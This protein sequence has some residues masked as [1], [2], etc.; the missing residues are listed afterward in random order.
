MLSGFW[1]LGWIIFQVKVQ[2]ELNPL[3]WATILASAYLFT[4]TVAFFFTDN[5]FIGFFGDY[6]RRTGYI[7]YFSLT[8]FFLVSAYVL[9][10]DRLALL[11]KAAVYIGLILGIYGFVQ[12]FKY[13]F[14]HWNNNYNLVI[15]TLG[16]PDF[17]AA[18]MA[19][20]LIL[21]FGIV[22]QSKKI[23]S[24][25]VIAALNVFLLFI[26]IIFSQ[27]RQALV[28]SALGL[29]IVTITWIY[30]RKR[31]IAFAST[32]F[33][34]AIG[35]LGLLGTLNKGPLSK[36]F[37]KISVTYRGDYWRAGWNM[38][39]HHP[40][41]GVG[42][43]RYGASFR[44][45][46]DATQSLRRGPNYVSN[47]AHS[48]PIQLAATG[49]VFVLITFLALTI[50]IFWRGIIALR[51]N[52]GQ[53]QILAAVIFAAWIA[54]ETQ[55]LISIDNL[56]I[57]VWGYILGGA[58]VGV[59]IV[60]VS[61]NRNT[62][63][64]KQVQ[65]Y[66]STFLL[67]TPFVISV[68]F[69]KAELSM[70]LANTIKPPTTQSELKEYEKLVSVPVSFNFKDPQFQYLIALKKAQ[71]G[72]PISAISDLKKIISDDPKNY[73]AQVALAQIY[74]FQ[75]DWSS[76]I[77]IRKKIFIIDPFNQQNL[78]NLGQDQ[79]FSGDATA[80]KAVIPLINAFAPNSAEAKQALT[81][82]GK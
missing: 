36:Y 17:A 3:K 19:I 63:K 16:N 72:D 59:S 65:P 71:A 9:R 46:R 74:E 22:F 26:V 79:K 67:L 8:I 29:I 38:F 64:S 35:I 56:A 24:L 60:G 10:I 20:F 82:L 73:D 68:L 51:D 80:A 76:A 31:S 69:M 52:Q 45:Y 25:R 1:L 66:V 2:I 50:F 13:D 21:N 42:L 11:E 75:K 47:A 37:Y 55:S 33:A 39:I 58:V 18:V 15:A 43:D 61:D 41:F 49:G 48:V 62:T 77:F 27:V 6:Q 81:T 78:L 70:H 57:A 32:L 40:L 14:V 34:T 12:H 54:Y 30:Q 28:T 23:R 4:M 5:T 44:Q 7:E 53:R